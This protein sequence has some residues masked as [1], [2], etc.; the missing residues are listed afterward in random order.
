MGSRRSY[1]SYNDGCA[2]SH[3]LDL[4]GG[5]WTLLVVRELLLGPKRF[6]D[7][8]RD[9]VGI[10]PTVLSQRLR[11]LTTRGIAV[12]RTL[13]APARVDVYELTPWGARLEDVNTA[14]SMWAA[15]SPGLPKE[16]DMSPDTLVLAMRAH[17][18]GATTLADPVSV[19]LSL[20]D[21][22]L[23]EAEAVPYVALVTP[24]E[25][26]IEKTPT[27]GPTDA[28]V[29]T[30]TAEWKACVLGGASLAD[31]TETRV[32]GSEAAVAALIEATRLPL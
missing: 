13:P 21:S 17:A 31:L 29:H 11:D 27:S 12:R 22:R 24:E 1:S 19:T 30:T 3:A 5:R 6:A 18:R 4:I 14:L 23:T 7:L 32:T 26:T 28:E 9:I 8:Q 20:I 16:A 25:T 10:S 15:A 2:A